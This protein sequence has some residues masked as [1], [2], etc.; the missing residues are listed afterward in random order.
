MSNISLKLDKRTAEGKK[1]AKLRDSGFVP[2]VVYGGQ[3]K[4]LMTQSQ[5]VETAKAIHSVGKH[6]PLD[7]IID[8]VKKLAIIKNIDMDPVKHQLR[9]IAFHTIRQN[10]IITTEVPIILVGVGESEAERIGLIIL[11]AIEH[12]E[13]KAKPADLPESFELSIVDLATAEDK[14]TIGDIKLPSGVEFADVDQDMDLVIANVYEPSAL[15]AA[16]EA[17]GGEAEEE[18]EVPVEGEA[19]VV[20]GAEA[21]AVQPDIE[22]KK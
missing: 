5:L 7:L 18:T 19:E 22:A 1:V 20:E 16:N 4:P 14:L 21:E 10:D 6:T 11:Q 3:S 2:S 15:Q 13:I 8:G 17:T 9:H 12:I